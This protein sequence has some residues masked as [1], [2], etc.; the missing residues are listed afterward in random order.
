M[1][2]C[3]AYVNVPLKYS[4]THSKAMGGDEVW[5]G[6]LYRLHIGIEV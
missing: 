6:L 4:L 5:R 1:A 3:I 2:I